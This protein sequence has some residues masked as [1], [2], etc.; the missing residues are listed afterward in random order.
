MPLFSD[1]HLEFNSV[2][3]CTG[4]LRK[5][6]DNGPE[7]SISGDT[8]VVRP[9]PYLVVNIVM[10]RPGPWVYSSVTQCDCRTHTPLNHHIHTKNRPYIRDR[11][12]S[13]LQSTHTKDLKYLLYYETSTLKPI[14]QSVDKRKQKMPSATPVRTMF[15]SFARNMVEPHPF[16]RSPVSMAPHAWR[17]GDLSK[18]LVRTSVV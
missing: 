15:R 1:L 3:S 10:P 5:A 6:L 11:H 8:L 17:A 13:I 14:D 18:R 7:A 16:A 9:H 2:F 4:T 12:R